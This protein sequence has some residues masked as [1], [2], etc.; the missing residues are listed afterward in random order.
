MALWV[1]EIISLLKVAMD[2]VESFMLKEEVSNLVWCSILAVL[3]LIPSTYSQVSPVIFR[4]KFHD[5]F[6]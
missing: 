5:L 6:S 4:Q 3:Y 2:K 1:L